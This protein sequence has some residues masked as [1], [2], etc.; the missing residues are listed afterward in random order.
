MCL[1]V[2]CVC[3]CVCVLCVRV[4]VCVRGVCVHVCVVHVHVEDGRGR[5]YAKQAFV[6]EQIKYSDIIMTSSC[7][8]AMTTS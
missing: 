6:L 8:I 5:F 4:G 2:V 7:V 3:V 1:C